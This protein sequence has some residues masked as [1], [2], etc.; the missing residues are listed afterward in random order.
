MSSNK[1]I[2][3]EII[4]KGLTAPRVTLER[5][6]SRIA[7]EYYLTGDE[8]EQMAI[9]VFGNASTTGS[10]S[11]HT[12]TICVLSLTNGFNVVGESA[13]ASPEN[14]DAALGRKIARQNAVNKIWMLE[15]YVL[16]QRLHDEES[17]QR[18]EDRS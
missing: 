11:I 12:L 10:S 6:E 4:S 3:E 16:R 8:I 17:I 1:E 18:T 13:P 14:F 2:E 7:F 5:I 15:G 9:G